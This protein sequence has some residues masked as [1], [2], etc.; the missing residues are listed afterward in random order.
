MS[1]LQNLITS[2]VKETLKLA[3][4]GSTLSALDY[5][6]EDIE[7][8]LTQLYSYAIKAALYELLLEEDIEKLRTL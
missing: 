1:Q 5:F 4:Q 7:K 6:E 2:Q 8:S 3:M